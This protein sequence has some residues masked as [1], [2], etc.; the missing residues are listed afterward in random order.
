MGDG[1]NGATVDLTVN[2]TVVLAGVS[3]QSSNPGGSDTSVFTAG[4][5]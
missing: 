1:W 5:R 2:G 4:T 3:D